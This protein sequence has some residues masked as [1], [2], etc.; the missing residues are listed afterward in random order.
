MS[1]K[2]KPASTSWVRD[3]TRRLH[4]L[5]QP[6]QMDKLPRTQPIS[7]VH[8]WDR[9]T[10]IDR[11]YIDQFLQ[12][13]AG[14]IQGHCLEVGDDRYTRQFGSRVTRCSVLD[15]DQSNPRAT[16]LADLSADGA[17]ASD[18]FDCFLLIQTLHLIYDVPSAVRNAHRVL[19]PGGV[20]LATL[21]AVG[22]LPN[23]G[24][25]TAFW[26]FT[27]ASAERLFA[28]SFGSDRVEIQYGGNVLTCTA[29]LMGLAHEE[30][31]REELDH[32]DSRFPLVVTVRAVK[33]P[34]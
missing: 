21:P 14:D 32:R 23:H 3:L 6:G 19:T 25:G 17:I 28:E 9:G 20:L 13:N 24:D 34:T 2:S 27:P 5:V 18:T 7:S 30:L 31:S 1:T 10:P 12:E 16:I 15:I 8:G 29:H 4:R 26:R 11:Y 22:R 33:A